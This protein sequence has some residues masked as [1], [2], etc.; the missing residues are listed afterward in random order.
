MFQGQKY[1]CDIESSFFSRSK[2]ERYSEISALKEAIIEIKDQKNKE[3]EQVKKE[4]D[5]EIR[6]I[7]EEMRAVKLEKD[8]FI[9]KLLK[10]IEMLKVSFFWI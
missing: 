6:E 5:G 1:V 7:K 2:E 10:E 8:R 9:E 4:K 3:V